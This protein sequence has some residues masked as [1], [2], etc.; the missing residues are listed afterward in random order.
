MIVGIVQEVRSKLVLEKMSLLNVPKVSVVRGGECINVDI[1]EVVLDDIME[2]HAG[3]QI[4]SDAVVVSGECEVNEEGTPQ[5][6]LISPLLANV[7]LDIMDEW[8]TGQWENKHTTHSYSTA[9][10]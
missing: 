9:R 5:G 1:S 2:I 3:E 7:Y 4:A 10:R 6:G 8:I